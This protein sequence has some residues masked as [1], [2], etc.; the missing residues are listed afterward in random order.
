MRLRR[1][2]ESISP[3]CVLVGHDRVGHRIDRIKDI[4]IAAI[5]SIHGSLDFSNQEN[6]GSWTGVSVFRTHVDLLKKVAPVS[7]ATKPY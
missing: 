3:P 5:K 1:I 2:A 6:G 7:P 4:E